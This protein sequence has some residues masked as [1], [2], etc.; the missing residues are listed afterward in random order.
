MLMISFAFI[1]HPELRLPLIKGERNGD[2]LVMIVA[3]SVVARYYN[4]RITDAH[5]GPS[6]LSEDVNA[7]HTVAFIRNEN[8]EEIQKEGRRRGRYDCT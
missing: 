6:I 4:A 7:E 2:E 3:L 8:G 5:L 1:M